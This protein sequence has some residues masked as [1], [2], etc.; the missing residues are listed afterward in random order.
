[1]DEQQRKLAEELLF[2]SAGKSGFAKKLFLGA[3]QADNIF[4]FPKVSEDERIKTEK[5]LK[6]VEA[7]ADANIN[8]DAIDREA[9]IPDNVIQGLAELGVLGMTIPTEYGG[10][11][12]S[13]YAYCQVTEAISRRCG[14]TALFI[15]AHQS[16]GLKALLLFGTEAQKQKWL[17]PLAQ[18]KFIAA[19]SLTEPT[20]GSDANGIQTRAVYD[21]EKKI[22]RLTGKK[23]WT[24]NGAF[25]DV[26]TVMART[27]VDTPQG[28]QDKITAFLI[29]PSMPGFKVTAAAL[30]KVGMRGSK[31]A[32]LEFNDV[33]VPEENILGPLGGGLKVCLTVL[34]FGRTTFGATCAGAAKFLVE[35]AISHAKSRYQFNRPLSSFGLVKYKLA[36]MSALLYAIQAT[37]YMTAGLI[38]NHVE[39]FMLE[40]AMLKVFSSDSLWSILYDTMQ[41]YGGHSFFTDHP[42]ERMMR[43]ARLNMI[44]EGSNEVMRVFIG[45]V[46][47]RDAGLKLQATLESVMHPIAQFSLLQKST[48]HW[49]SRL[50]IPVVPLKS[51]LLKEEGL[52]LGQKVRSFGLAVAKLLIKYKEDIIERQLQLDRIATSAMALY[53]ASATLSYLDSDMQSNSKD[54]KDD[55]ATAKLYCALAFKTIDRQLASISDNCDDTIEN[56]SDQLTGAK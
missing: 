23:Q 37:T 6:R 35:K 53:T 26:L 21:P 11:G 55:I 33:D 52:V 50:K 12:M 24:T 54:F 10:L 27:E 30:E 29:T 48:I 18:G 14:S 22:W 8:A 16:I 28:K 25:A 4:P 42:F 47:M 2:S 31:T 9:S 41:I 13:Q 15:N 36:T 17:A 7:F 51:P 34:D 45:A 56:L 44:G 1:M 49:L 19:F 3:F 39:D 43:D 46:G 20:A 5:L 40:S 32:N 38:D